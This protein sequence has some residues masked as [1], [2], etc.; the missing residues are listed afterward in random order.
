MTL[1]E[2]EQEQN[3]IEN[4]FL[5]IRSVQLRMYVPESALN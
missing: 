2:A 4:Y 3:I 1:G 5:Q